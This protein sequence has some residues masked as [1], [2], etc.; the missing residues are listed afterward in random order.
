MA[1]RTS[2]IS[3]SRGRPPGLAGGINGAILSH[4]ASVRSLW[5]IRCAPAKDFQAMAS[6]FASW[7]ASSCSSDAILVAHPSTLPGPPTPTMA[8]KPTFHTAS[9][10]CVRR[11]SRRCY[12]WANGLH[13]PSPAWKAPYAAL[14]RESVFRSKKS[15]PLWFVHSA[16]AERTWPCHLPERP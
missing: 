13:P 4:S 9:K 5:G 7:W 6:A 2:R 1:L 12:Q 8:S 3:T 16:P 15:P 11:F 10:P 14:S